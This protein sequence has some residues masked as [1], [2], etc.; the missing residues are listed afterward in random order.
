LPNSPLIIGVDGGGTKTVAWLACW[1]NVASVVLGRGHAGPGNPRAAGFETALA[2]ID[3]AINAAFA[4]ARLDRTTVSAACFCLAG[5]GREQ[6]QLRITTWADQLQIASSIAVKGD[7]EPIVAAASRDHMGIALISGTGSL[8]WGRNASGDVART[9]GWGYLLGDEGSAYAIAR[10]ALTA[11]VKAADGRG[12]AT[13]LLDQILCDLKAADT[14][15][16]VE[17]IYGPAMTRERLAGLAAVVFVSATSD[18]VARGI[19][20]TAASDL[21]EMVDTLRR[22]LGF[23]PKGYSLALAGSVILNQPLLR[24]LLEERLADRGCT[25]QI[26]HSVDEPVAGAIALARRLLE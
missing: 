3:A 7:A 10:A 26:I 4:D 11:A 16:L 20:E 22:R 8:A 15:E 5:A 17:R 25:P 21:A 12:T 19:I 9:G 13:V 6:E 2:N 23:Q 14:A 1:D 18:P 24:S